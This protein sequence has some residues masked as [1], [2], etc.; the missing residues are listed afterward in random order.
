MAAG[1]QFRSEGNSYVI[2]IC[3]DASKSHPNSSVLQD[4]SAVLGRYNDTDIVGRESWLL[5]TYGSGDADQ[6]DET[7]KSARRVQILITCKEENED[8]SLYF[9][10]YNK[11]WN[12]TGCFFSFELQT[13]A[14]CDQTGLSSGSV[15]CIIFLTSLGIYFLIG[16]T[17]RR[18][19]G[20]AKGFEQ[21]PHQNFWKELG[22][23]QADGCNFVCRRD[24]HREESWS[25]LTNTF[26][27]PHGDRDD[28]LLRP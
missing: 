11:N 13:S 20:G 15:L 8:A 4:E 17:Y 28:A 5:L 6:K 22:N 3:S 27:E 24:N 2:T 21:I 26:N 25:R 19:I 12:A 23:L 10:E 16:V 18:M 9:L 14:V 7:C 1:F